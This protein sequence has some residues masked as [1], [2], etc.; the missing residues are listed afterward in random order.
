M[1]CAI[2]DGFMGQPRSKCRRVDALI[3][4]EFSSRDF[5]E[6]ILMFRQEKAC[7]GNASSRQ[8]AMILCYYLS[9]IKKNFIPIFFIKY[10]YFYSNFILILTI[11]FM[12][13]S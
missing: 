11:I 13:I 1:F 6:K 8:Y 7:G 4:K 9:T 10:L 2:C 3:G 5:E 12:E